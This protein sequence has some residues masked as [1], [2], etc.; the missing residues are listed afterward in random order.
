M[1]KTKSNVITTYPADI[2][3][4]QEEEKGIDVVVN[5]TPA[6]HLEKYFSIK[7]YDLGT[8]AIAYSKFGRTSMY[9]LAEWDNLIKKELSRNL[10]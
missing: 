5:S 7:K 8:Q 1:S 6:I 4:P 9:T 10:A 2:S 3:E